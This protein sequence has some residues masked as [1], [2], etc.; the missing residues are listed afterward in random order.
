MSDKSKFKMA[1]FLSMGLLFRSSINDV[2]PKGVHSMHSGLSIKLKILSM[3]P[4]RG[5]RA[6]QG[7]KICFV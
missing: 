4:S 2:I 3:G 6:H 1:A 5:E 7:L